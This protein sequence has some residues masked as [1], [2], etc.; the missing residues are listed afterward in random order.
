MIV[1]P[2]MRGELDRTRKLL[3]SAVDAAAKLENDQIES[4]ARCQELGIEIGQLCE[5]AL[6][7][8]AGILEG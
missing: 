5:R 6:Y 7:R 1:T 2:A 4:V 3:L 8:L